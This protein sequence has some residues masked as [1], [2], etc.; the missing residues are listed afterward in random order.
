[1][2]GEVGYR[3]SDFSHTLRDPQVKPAVEEVRLDEDRFAR[4]GMDPTRLARIPVRMQAFVD[5]GTIPGA[6]ML[7]A[8]HRVVAMLD[9]VGYRDL[10]SRRPMRTDTIVDIASMT[11]MF[12]TVAIMIL[13]EEGLLTLSDP[14]EK[15]LPEF[16]GQEIIDSQ[17]AS[18]D[19]VLKKPSR[20]I[21]IYDLLTHTSGMPRAESLPESVK[22]PDGRLRPGKT[23]TDLVAVIAREPLEF[24]PGTRCL[25]SNWGFPPLGRII[26]LVSG[27]RYDQ[28][29]ERRIFQ[30]L[31]M[32]DTFYVPPL[33]KCERIAVSYNLEQGRLKREAD[34]DLYRKR[35]GAPSVNPGGGWLSTAAD[36]LA[37]SQMIATGGTWNNTRILSRAAVTAMTTLQTGGLPVDRPGIGRGLGFEI[38]TGPP[39]TLGFH[40]VGT[41]GHSGRTGTF[42]WVDPEKDLVGLFFIQRK[43]EGR[44]GHGPERKVFAAMAA[45]AVED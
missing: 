25:Y 34:A 30:P 14:V 45:A 38:V 8:R 17:D 26:E 2:S 28:F 3:P 23:L 7:L 24:E 39:A 22:G 5:E 11:K 10:E 32:T 6:V 33:E 27:E 16:G 18:T 21:T 36:M 4:A 19:R 35:A 15:H 12:T 13:A 41:Y 44:A 9:T 31:G 40:S 29:V 42:G 1:M 37:F 20:P 43:I